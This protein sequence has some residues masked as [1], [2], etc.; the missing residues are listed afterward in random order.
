MK[1]YVI[2]GCGNA[3]VKAAVKIKEIEKHALIT[4]ITDEDYP[5]YCRCLLTYF[6]ENK[7]NDEFLF[8]EGR[9][10]IKNNNI[11]FIQNVKVQEVDANKSEI[12]LSNNRKLGFDKLLISTGGEPSLPKFKYN[13]GL[14]VFTLRKFEDALKIKD[15]FKKG[16][17]AVIEGGGLVSLKTLLAL[18]EI[19]VKI[20]WIVKSEYILSFLV[21]RFSA[22]FIK[23][24]IV[25][26]KGIEIYNNESIEDVT[27]TN[28]ALIV[29]TDKGREIKASGVVVGKG[30]KPKKLNFNRAVK[31]EDGYI[32]NEYLETTVPNIYAA[33]DC[34]IVFDVAHEKNWK[35]PLWP[36][37][38]EQGIC[39]AINM[40]KGNSMKY[41][42]AVPVNSFSI[43]ENKIIAGGKKKLN[44]DEVDLFSE[45]VYINKGK[46]I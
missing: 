30:V 43:F 16:D 8:Q 4:V 37:A 14:P 31:F 42:S 22:E 46:K 6:I 26:N 21:D 10:I 36:L 40:V 15:A 1:R 12:F 18:N 23:S 25:E 33:G 39:A 11:E 44:P 24:L 32:T 45:K 20:K 27:K 9:Q 41:I 19:G 5:P 28:S 7:I 2:I 17:T 3:G 38:G 35:V 34:N 29:K 13:E